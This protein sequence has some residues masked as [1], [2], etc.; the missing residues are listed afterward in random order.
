MVGRH[1]RPV[2]AAPNRHLPARGSVWDAA[3]GPELDLVDAVRVARGCVEDR[4]GTAD[5]RRARVRDDHLRAGD[6]LSN[7]IVIG[8]LV[9]VSAA[10]KTTA[11]TVYVPS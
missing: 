3:R 2:K 4:A 6:A 1:A 10:S 5:R 8:S 11:R 9:L 7:V